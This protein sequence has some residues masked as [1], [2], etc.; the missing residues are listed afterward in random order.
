M[1]FIEQLFK[2][3][4]D[5]GPLI[6]GCILLCSVIAV[7][8]IIDRVLY[9]KKIN[10]KDEKIIDRLTSAINGKRFDEALAICDTSPSPVTNMMKSGINHKDMPEHYIQEA[11]KGA[12]NLEIPKLEKNLTAL[13]TIANISTLLGL[14][15]TVLG[16]MEAFGLIGSKGAI[17]SMEVLAGGIAKALLTTAFGLIVSIPTSIFYNYF[18]NKVNNMILTLETQ[19][20]ELVLVIVKGRAANRDK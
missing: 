11:I 9:L 13:G 19:A 20:N 8:I 6:M 17:G 7:I 4:I 16:N 1:K 12:A 10:K 5:G 2:M 18:T 14:L 15:G 3:F